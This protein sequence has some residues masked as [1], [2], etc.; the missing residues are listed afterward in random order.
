MR[1]LHIFIHQTHSFVLSF[2]RS[3]VRYSLD[4]VFV[5]WRVRRVSVW[6]PCNIKVTMI[7]HLHTNI[8]LSIIALAFSTCLLNLLKLFQYIKHVKKKQKKIR[9][10]LLTLNFSPNHKQNCKSF[11][12]V[13]RLFVI[14]IFKCQ[15]LFYFTP[16]FDTK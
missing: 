15:R 1:Q 2:V 7:F 11:I 16:L 4:L 8:M 9:R 10:E 5:V 13:K 3:F 6:F 14:N 12:A